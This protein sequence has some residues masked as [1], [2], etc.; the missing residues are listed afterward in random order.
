[1]RVG[2][3]SIQKGLEDRSS[4]RQ[5]LSQAR[6]YLVEHLGDRKGALAERIDRKY[7]QKVSKVA[8]GVVSPERVDKLKNLLLAASGKGGASSPASTRT[9]F[10]AVKRRLRPATSGS[11]KTLTLKILAMNRRTA[12]QSTAPGTE[13]PSVGPRS[14]RLLGAR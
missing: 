3:D 12:G 5:I 6:A 9:G 8:R 4:M 7:C 13:Q 1:M 2:A 11:H 10:T 14:R